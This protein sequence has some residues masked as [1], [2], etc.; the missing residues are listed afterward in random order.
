MTNSQ[1]QELYDKAA[2]RAAAEEY[3]KG[4]DQRDK[5]IWSAILSSDCVLEGTGFRSEGLEQCLMS[6]DQLTQMF[7]ATRHNVSNQTAVI[8]GDSASG[9]T[10][11]IAD[12]VIERDGHS[13]ILSWH[14]RYQDEWR[15]EEGVWKFTKR[16]LIVDWEET[17]AIHQPD[18]KEA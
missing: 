4:A 3:A 16:A 12:H 18:I 1:L 14:I 7:I 15:R 17:R 9:E 8:D 2:L 10:Y 5:E 11:C 13:E 6:I